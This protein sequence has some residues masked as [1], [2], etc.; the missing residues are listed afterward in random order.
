MLKTRHSAFYR[1][2]LTAL[3]LAFALAA[4]TG[5]VQNTPVA[6]AASFTPG[7]IVVVRIGDGSAAL[8]NAATA[9]FLDEYTPAGTIVQTISLPTTVSG[10]NKRLTMSGTST[11]DGALALS[12]NGQYLTLTGY[13]AITGTA[14]VTSSAANT[15]NRIVGRLNANGVVDTSTT[16]TNDYSTNNIRSAV[17]DNGINIWTGGAGTNPGVRYTTLGT[18][19]TATQLSTATP[20]NIR[21][22]NIFDG[23]LYFATGSTTIGIYKIG[24]GLPTTSGQLITQTVSTSGS[25]YGFVFFDRDNTIAGVDTLYVADDSTGTAGGLKKFSYNGT[26]WT[27]QGAIFNTGSNG[28]RGLTGKIEN[29]NVVLYGTTGESSANKL[30]RITDTAAYNASLAASS[31][32]LTTAVAN[33]VFRGVAFVP[34]IAAPV[35]PSISQQPQSQ[36]INF[37]TS[38]TLTITATGTAPL[39]YQWYQGN[40]GD[41]SNPLAGATSATFNTG[42]LT[43]TTNYWVRVSNGQGNA[44]SN[45]ATV[46]VNPPGNTPPQIGAI[47][48]LSGVISDPTNP[49]VSF[50]VSDTETAANQLVVAATATTNAGVASLANVTVSNDGNGNR[51][52]RVNPVG[53]GYADISVTVTDTGNL[54]ATTTLK[55]AASATSGTPSTSR[56]H[57]GVADASTAIALDGSYMLVAD[58]ENQVLRL[59][60]RANSGLPL[61]GFDF[62]SSL[63]LTDI[64]G[65]QPR[66]VDIE[67]SARVG[68][69]VYWL[70]SHSNSSSGNS[71]PNRY[72]IFATDIAGS[73]ANSTLSYV[74]RY[75][76]LRADLIAW[77][78]NNGHGKG[79]NYYGLAASAANGVIPEAAD[80]S[81]FNIEGFEIAPGGAAGLIGFRAP[82]SPASSRT[83]ALLVPVTNLDAL[84]SGN[85]GTGP[86]QFGAPIEL[87]LGGRGIREI[88]RSNNGQ[89]YLIVA[90]PAD[91]ATGV[92]PKD[93]RLYT[94]SGNPAEA[95]V[96]RT[97]DLTAL[98]TGGS[99]E[100]IVEVPITLNGS[101][102]IQL[103]SDNGDTIFYNDGII[104]KDLAEPRFKKFRS[105]VVTLGAIVKTSPTITLTSSPNPSKVGQSVI[106]TATVS[107]AS[108]TPTGT[109]IFTNTTT[110]TQLGTAALFN[111]QAVL[112][113]I[114]FDT[115]NNYNIVAGYS[116]NDFYLDSVSSG[117]I[118]NVVKHSSAVTLTSSPNPAKIGENVTF[119]ATVTGASGTPTGTVIFTNTTTN[120]QLGT[121]DLTNGQA[122]LHNVTFNTSG[123]FNIVAGYGGSPVYSGSVSATYVQNVDKLPSTLTLTSSPNPSQIA[124]TVV[125]TATVTGSGATPTGTVVFTNTTSNIQ[126]GTATLNNSGVATITVTTLPVGSNNILAEYQGNSAYQPVADTLIQ[127]VGL[128]LTTLNLTSTPNP[129][130]FGQLVTFTASLNPATAT[131]TVTF[132][133]DN[134]QTLGTRPVVNGSAVL[135]TSSLITGSHQITATYSGDAVYGAAQDSA[136]HVVNGACDPLKVTAITDN[137]QGT[138]C[139]TLSYA[140]SQ[141]APAT[142]TFALTQGNII[143]FTGSLTVPVKPGVIV[144]GGACGSPNQIGLNG[145]GV[146]GFGLN[147]GGN[148]ILRNLKIYGFGGVQITAASGGNKLECVRVSKS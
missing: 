75:D 55:Y 13:D 48:A 23:Q 64:S 67:A 107:G 118:Q 102:Q 81:G 138:V 21:V 40:S 46:T 24:E 105:D 11:S 65:G 114:V 15:T 41:T 146:A 128:Q 129:S 70:A 12:S 134:N 33:T 62:T 45:T 29:G 126:L 30:V 136:T 59:Y 2:A 54:S 121:A 145:A 90:G 8:T 116:G 14:S 91:V 130:I 135:T 93:F 103:L 43:A 137:G 87:D 44:D 79:A 119:T 108:E 18:V 86:A 68:N 148:N 110:N 10:N 34:Q 58:D 6:H 144:N 132:V 47:P 82:I 39:T 1:Y 131:G 61:N 76:G 71:R 57:T 115:A 106:F 100:A 52:I 31:T 95:P 74:G 28:L 125:F 78:Q 111:G 4:F 92:A 35:A 17:S 101:S 123:A 69:R 22:V 133:A 97:A 122:V 51:T 36:T 85:P 7:N 142:I 3:V 109:V 38:A 141:S 113:N 20:T 5:L 120:T 112:N 124:Q 42:N 88:R 147:L 139:G 73:G 25:P 94:W 16:L 72:R 77:D 32:D 96:L 26:A 60:D 19:G 143:T 80:G 63:G 98:N 49:G 127:V 84:L 53:V 66:E 56:F 83:K 89:H 140:L 37:N 27:Q 9:V 104:A 117:Y 50:V 99:F